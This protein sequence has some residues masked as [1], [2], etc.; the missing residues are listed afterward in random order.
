MK[1]RYLN[2]EIAAGGPLKARYLNIEIAVGDPFESKVLTHYNRCWGSLRKQGA[3]IFQL[4]LGA[5]ASSVLT[6]CSLFKA[7]SMNFK[8]R[9]VTH[10]SGCWPL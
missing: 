1:A 3:Y 9:V 10:F 6:H 7:S 2:I 5:S 4:R 8:S